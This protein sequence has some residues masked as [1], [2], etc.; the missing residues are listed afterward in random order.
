MARMFGFIG[1]RPD[2]GARVLEANALAWTFYLLGKHPEKCPK[3]CDYRINSAVLHRLAQWL[4]E[5]PGVKRV[6]YPGLP[7]HPGHEL[8]RRQQRGFGAIVSVEI[9]G[10]H[11]GVRA[12]VAE[13]ECFSLAESLGGVE[14]LVA[15]PATMTHAAMDPGA[16]LKAGLVKKLSSQSDPNSSRPSMRARGRC[17]ARAAARCGTAC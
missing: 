13:L 5:Q 1:N 16:R 8:A 9:A 17:L 12:F 2:L 3:G 4:N 7:G 15:H 6:Y 11:E 14:S 10:G